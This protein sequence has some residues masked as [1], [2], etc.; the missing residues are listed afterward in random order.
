MARW[1]PAG[2]L[3]LVALLGFVLLRLDA[4]GWLW[5][6]LTGTDQGPV[7]DLR[8]RATPD[9]PALVAAQPGFSLDPAD[10]SILVVPAGVHEIDETLVIPA[11]ASLR[12]EPGA[13]L[14]FAPG[15][16][17]LSFGPVTAR[18]SAERPIAFRA[19]H[20]WL[21]WGVVGVLHAGPS[22]FEHVR[23][24]DTRFATVDGVLLPGGLSFVE[25][26]A[27]V[28]WSEFRDAAGKDAVYARQGRVEVHDNLFQDARK[29]GLD[30]DDASGEVR[31]NRFVD[32]DDEAID[33]SGEGEVVVLGNLILDQRGGRMAADGD[34]AA[35]RA[36]NRFGH[37]ED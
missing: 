4:S 2:A 7:E 13:E 30:L 21:K 27:E 35:Y 32:C 5:F 15:R 9:L 10:P 1:V 29:D 8:G 26:D 23:F 18:G 16:S 34:L 33:L 36:G 19:R 14:R 24:E 6:R 22:S 37:S 17:L 25:A 12:I 20:R 11:G 28:A 3:L 31:A